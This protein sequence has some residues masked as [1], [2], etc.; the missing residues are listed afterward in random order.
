MAGKSLGARKAFTLRLP[1]PMF[2][3]LEEMANFY[4]VSM[5][6]LVQMILGSNLRTADQ[7]SKGI[8]N[9]VVDN[10]EMNTAKEM[11]AKAIQ[12]GLGI[13]NGQE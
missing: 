11:I 7:L 1:V 2:E 12:K 4:G 5:Q 13:P 10:E 3:Q 9:K 6:A 8:I